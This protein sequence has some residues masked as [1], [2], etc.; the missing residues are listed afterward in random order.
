[1]RNLRPI[2]YS[3]LCLCIVVACSN[4][5]KLYDKGNYDKAYAKAL[6]GLK[7]GKKNRDNLRVLNRSFEKIMDEKMEDIT[8]LKTGDL[9][10]QE[11]AIKEYGELIEKYEE[12]RS[13]IDSDLDA[14]MDQHYTGKQDLATSV[15][16]AYASSAKRKLNQA[17]VN[18]NKLDAQTAF[19]QFQKAIHYD[20]K[21]QF[22]L[23]SLQEVALIAGTVY[24]EVN[25]TSMDFDLGWELDRVFDDIET[26]IREDFVVVQYGGGLQEVDCVIELS[27]SD[28]SQYDDSDVDSRDFEERVITG[29]NTEV[30]TSG[31]K[32]ETPIYEEV[33]GTV[34]INKIR[35][36]SELAMIADL[37]RSTGVC[38]FNDGRKTAGTYEELEFYETY[39]DDRAIPDKYKRRNNDEFTDPKRIA[40]DL[41]DDLYDDFRRMW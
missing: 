9:A 14:Q 21:D 27:F 10:D 15:S 26:D 32:T 39:G 30:D 38:D 19:Y 36:T 31:N 23:D 12:G 35:R 24:Y 18:G 34:R 2:L 20:K 33:T 7:K 5:K 4:P 25:R 6:S 8:R 3:I 29:Y 28:L 37:R 11:K 40:E 13:F 41:I 17:I 22:V 1:M 16:E